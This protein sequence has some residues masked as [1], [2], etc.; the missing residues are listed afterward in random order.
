MSYLA[1]TVSDGRTVGLSDGRRVLAAVLLSV[2]PTVRLSGQGT[3]A[4]GW[5]VGPPPWGG[6]GPAAAERRFPGD[7]PL[8]AAGPAPREEARPPGLDVPPPAA[9]TNRPLPSA[10]A[11]LPAP[12]AAGGAACA[13][14]A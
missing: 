2:S 8:V 12:S 9:P 6:A 14:T 4:G 13:A 7:A 1:R 11:L 5:G 3:V 10:P